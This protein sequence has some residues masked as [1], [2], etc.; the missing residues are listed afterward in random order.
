MDQHKV[1]EKIR[2]ASERNGIPE[3]IGFKGKFLTKFYEDV[4]LENQIYVKAENKE[5]VSKFV[6]NTIYFL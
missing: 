5:T 6:S 3:I 2:I 4:V 1:V